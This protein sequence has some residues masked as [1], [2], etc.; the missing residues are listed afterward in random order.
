M[1]MLAKN[2]T[3]PLVNV[4]LRT[5]L[6]LSTLDDLIP[7]LESLLDVSGQIVVFDLAGDVYYGQ[8]QTVCSSYLKEP[9]LIDNARIALVGVCESVQGAANIAAHMARTLSYTAL[10]VW[11]RQKLSD[12]VLARY[13]ELNLLYDLGSLIADEGM[14]RTEIVETLLRKT[15][16]IL[17]AEAGAIYLYSDGEQRPELIPISYFGLHHDEQF[18]SGRMLELARSALYA[19]ETTQL[20]EGGKVICAPLRQGS[21]RQGAVVFMHERNGEVFNASDVHLLTT[22]AHNTALFIQAA[23]L[24]T[25]LTQRN[26]EL[27]TTL[28]ELQSARRELDRAERLSIIGQ[29]VSGLVHDMRNP[30]NIVMGYAGLLQEGTL[31]PAE[32]REY[33]TQ[34][35]QYVNMFSAMMQEVLDYTQSDDRI[36]KTQVSVAAYMSRIESLLA[37]PGLERPVQIDVVYDGAADCIVSI[38]PDRFFRVFQNLVNN[39]VDAIEEHGGSRV[40]VLA[41]RVTDHQVRFAVCDD[42]PGVPPE[43]LQRMFDPFV[44]GKAR[45][46]GLGLAIVKRMIENHDGQIEYKTG[47]DGGACF[48]F[49]LSDFS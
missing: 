17:R 20:F 43:I 12:E 26:Q 46:T 23:R 19:Y 33:A 15:R 30:L 34:I 10:E 31:S 5:V 13:E 40:V 18:W 4:K 27:E 16:H 24:W 25:W 28:A 32:N 49:T 21:E 22:M 39:A 42:G 36:E 35:I 29:T 41:D 45:G 7:S 48:E 3:Y 2:D 38:D 8:T 6:P 37:P 1:L 11:R 44:T 9:I 14:T 47:P